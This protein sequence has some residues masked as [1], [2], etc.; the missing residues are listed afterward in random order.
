MPKKR[1]PLFTALA[2]PFALCLALAAR[3]HTSTPITLTCP[4]DGEKFSSVATV[5]M[6]TFGSYLDFQKHGAI[7]SYYEDIIHSCPKCHFAGTSDEF[8]EKV[9]A[10]IAERVRAE[11][12]PIQ[13]GQK[14]DHV[15]ECEFAARIYEWQGRKS[16]EIGNVYLIASYLLR[17]DA[18]R[19][20]KRR[21]LQLTAGRYFTK[22]LE[23]KELG[24]A[25]RAAVSY[26]VAELHR[27]AGEFDKAVTW[28]DAAL[29][30]QEKPEWLKE[31]AAK[32]RA[33]AVKKDAN[34][35]I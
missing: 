29:G 26:L 22:A 31:V 21:E 5:S 27:R 16:E 9:D 24:G 19:Q 2:L 17:D 6:T 23:A 3:P 25:G 15:T 4:V 7:G 35:K 8:K 33:L 13:K 28:Y 18:A 14:L 30:D 34:N 1:L 20:E 10:K 12:A 11:L 32:Q